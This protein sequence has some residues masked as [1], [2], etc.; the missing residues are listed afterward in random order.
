MRGRPIGGGAS[1]ASTMTPF[2]AVL[3]SGASPGNIYVADSIIASGTP[4]AN[5]RGTG[6]IDLQI[7]RTTADQIASGLY[8]VIV[9]GNNNTASG[10]QSVVIG[11]ESNTASGTYSVVAGGNTNLASKTN[12]SVGGGFNNSAS[13][14]SSHVGGGTGHTT[15]GTTSYIGGGSSNTASGISSAVAGGS[16]NTASNTFAFVGGGGG[17]TA[18]GIY[19]VIAG[20]QNNVASALS[21]TIAGGSDNQVTGIYG[22]CPGGWE[23]RN[24][25]YGAGAWSAGKFAAAGDCQVMDIH[26]R[27]TTS[28]A[29]PTTLF[30]DGAGGSSRRILVPSGY[31]WCFTATTFGVDSTG[32]K[33]G[34]YIRKGMIANVGGVTALIGAITTVGTDTETDAGLDVTI[35]ADDTND[36]LNINVTGLAANNFRWTC[37][38]EVQQLKYTT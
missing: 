23:I 35:T 10:T 22:W 5:T 13:G 27:N 37:H 14:T 7:V 28:D 17:N 16:T 18:S 32:A 2:T 1:V 15:S 21:S 29:T 20:G 38:L 26:A 19:A 8:A 4:S 36:A 9:G 12:S 33:A 25:L 11:G 3:A 30:L 31:A 24:P 6:S 34:H